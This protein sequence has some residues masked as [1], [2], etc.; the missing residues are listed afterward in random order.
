MLLLSL[1]NLQTTLN[2]NMTPWACFTQLTI[3]RATGPWA[4]RM[5]LRSCA[6][7]SESKPDVFFISLVGIQGCFY[8][9]S[10]QSHTWLWPH[11]HPYLP[12]FF[13]PNFF[14]WL[15]LLP[16][17]PVQQTELGKA[18]LVLG[19]MLQ[20]SVGPTQ[21]PVCQVRP[22][23]LCTCAEDWEMLFFTFGRAKWCCSINPPLHV[24][25]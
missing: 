4:P 5:P 22:P 20:F 3:P 24:A 23:A 13:L 7:S 18:A 2:W 12:N 14:F 9:T 6:L 25:Q 17:L 1:Y 11:L 19:S 16:L 15:M 21:H 10:T 8:S